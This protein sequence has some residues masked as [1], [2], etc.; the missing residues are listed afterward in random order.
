MPRSLKATDVSARVALRKNPPGVP[1]I[2]MIGAADLM[3]STLRR[4]PFSNTGW[5]F[6]WKYDGFRLLVCKHGDSVE[7][8]S[9]P[10][11]SLN[12]AF[13]ELVD[14]IARVDGSFVWDCELTTGAARGSEAFERVLSRACMSVA[15][16]IRAA[17]GRYPA[18]ACVFDILAIGKRDLRGL[19]MRERKLILRDTFED[20]PHLLYATGVPDAGELVFEQVVQHDFEGM[21]AKRLDAPYRRG[22]SNDWVKVKNQAYSRKAALGFR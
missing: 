16:R 20:T 7:L 10:G 6:E 9:R 19:P 22:R 2:G 4:E 5:W 3:L 15:P 21:V 1:L 8:L 12:R 17:A 11:N 14:A 18:R 13:P